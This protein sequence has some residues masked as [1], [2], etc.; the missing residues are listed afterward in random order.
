MDTALAFKWN[1]TYL[2]LVNDNNFPFDNMVNGFYA[3]AE[4]KFNFEDE[5]QIERIKVMT[6]KPKIKT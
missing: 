2:Q 4:C 6:S 1:S 5:Y 3:L